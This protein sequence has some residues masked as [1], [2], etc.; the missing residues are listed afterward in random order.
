MDS[1][2]TD[3][4]AQ[5]QLTPL[6]ERMRPRNLGEVAGQRQVVDVLR[7]LTQRKA[8]PSLIL[9][10]PPGCGKTTIARLLAGERYAFVP[11][12]AV[13]AG[14]KEVREAVELARQRRQYENK[15]TLLFLDEIH[16]FNKA[17][18]DVLLPHVEAGT[19]VLV[20]ATTENPS[21]E[22]VGPL[23]SRC[24]VLTLT[25][26]SAEDIEQVLVRAAADRERGIGLAPAQIEDGLLR[27]IAE[28]AAG[29]ARFALNTLEVCAGLVEEHAGSKPHAASGSS[30]DDGNT[31]GAKPCFA[32]D[33]ADNE[34]E[35]GME[36]RAKHDFAPT[37]Q[38][39]P[40]AS[41]APLLTL[42]ILK[43]AIGGGAH[44]ALL[45]DKGGDEHFNLISALHKSLRGS[46]PDAGL[47][48]LA[49]MLEAGEDPKYLVRRLIRF[50]SEDI[51]LAD[52]WALMQ[53]NA[54]RQAVEFL[55]MPECNT[56]L[57]QLVVYLACA[58]KSNAMY[59][60][61]GR[62][63]DAAHKH[64]ALPPP[65]HIRNAPTRLMKELGYGKDYK[66]AHDFAGGFV[67]DNYWPDELQGN[68]PRLL[69]LTGRGAEKTL[70]ERLRKLWGERFAGG[71]RDEANPSATSTS[72]GEAS[73]DTGTT[74][75]P[76][77]RPNEDSHAAAPGGRQADLGLMKS[78]RKLPHWRLHGSA[79]FIT[80]R[81][82]KDEPALTP[83]ERAIVSEAIKFGADKRYQL[84]AFVVMD[85]HAHCVILPLD[86]EDVASIV[87]TW[88]SYTT[89]QLHRKSSR[90]GAIWDSE[91]HDRLI[92]DEHE[93]NEKCEYVLTNPQRRWPEQTSYEWAGWV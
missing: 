77:R 60:A 82:N 51:G 47:Y 31:V 52:P 35:A 1:L 33:D 38:D 71:E 11:M 93:L 66:Y 80:W 65:L 85:D 83:A 20:G 48:W 84:Y 30:T 23:L 44:R 41:S 64:G 79:Y 10:G 78:Q 42:S 12:S 56:A 5:Q 61:Y 45:Y 9:W 92:R 86:G 17:Q 36:E 57:T 15:G 54:A 21:F 67:A 3:A 88:K 24:R 43:R 29:D 39:E 6:A 55:G 73:H 7:E 50:A 8:L 40:Y 46:D 90:Q 59:L 74:A 68:P 22:V 14:V 4:A 91:Y 70:V 32:Q 19:I 49:R 58:P 62:A 89:S 25:S 81:L 28:L 37:G 53:A 69:E 63:R 27:R 76:G 26:L 2:F 34:N 72:T 75:V 87:H 16:R 18:Q 13:L